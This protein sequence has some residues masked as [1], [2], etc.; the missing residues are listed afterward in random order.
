MDVGSKTFHRLVQAGV[1]ADALESFS[2]SDRKRK[3]D[4][5]V[6]GRAATA[7][8][9]RELLDR[10]AVVAGG[11]ALRVALGMSERAPDVD[12]FVCGFPEWV[13]ATLET[14]EFPTL[15]VCWYDREPWETFDLTASM[16]A[17][18]SDGLHMSPECERTLETGVCDVI[19]DRVFH[20]VATLGRVVKYGKKYGFTFPAQKLVRIAALHGVPDQIL[21]SAMRFTVRTSHAAAPL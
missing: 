20:P 12:V 9:L 8:K 18:G 14:R 4:G 13:T 21:Q 16:C 3:I 17:L 6:P 7:N 19:E 1:S 15:D 2:R 11:A 5:A 10:G